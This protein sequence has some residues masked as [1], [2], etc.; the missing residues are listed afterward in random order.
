MGDRENYNVEEDISI[1]KETVDSE[2]KSMEKY[3]WL[4]SIL[5][6]LVLYG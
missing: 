6:I 3:P 1:S 2:N 4:I 5:Y